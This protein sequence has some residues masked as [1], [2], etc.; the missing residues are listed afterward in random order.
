[1]SE[2]PAFPRVA[3]PGLVVCSA[4]RTDFRRLR[5]AEELSHPWSRV[6]QLHTKRGASDEQAGFKI[7]A[8]RPI[9]SLEKVRFARSWC[10]ERFVSVF[11]YA[12]GRG[13]P[14][15]GCSWVDTTP[16]NTAG[17]VQIESGYHWL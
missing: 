17:Q 10:A 12:A 1:M 16:T 7:G 2:A 13:W 3:H 15:A 14:P 6:T 11:I 9:L 8:R 4:T 5:H